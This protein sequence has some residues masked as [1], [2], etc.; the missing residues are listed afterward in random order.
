MNGVM[1]LE[2]L[3]ARVGGHVEQSGRGVDEGNHKG[4]SLYDSEYSE[5][6]Y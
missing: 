4:N 5:V 1:E 2:A 6:G 3:R